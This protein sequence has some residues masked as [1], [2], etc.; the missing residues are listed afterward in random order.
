MPEDAPIFDAWT[1]LSFKRALGKRAQPGTSWLAPTWVGRH[2]RRLQ[3]YKMLQAYVDNAARMY[4]AIDSESAKSEHREYGDSALL[5]EVI[6]SA[7]LGDDQT[8][9]V[10]T[11]TGNPNARSQSLQTWLEAWADKE[12]LP[13]KV[14]E[15]ERNACNLGDGVYTLGWS[16][17]KK[18]VRLRVF[19]PGFYFPALD[20][21]NED[22]YPSRVHIAWEVDDDQLARAGQIKVRRITW[23]LRP[24][25][26]GIMHPWND[27]V[28]THSC[29]LTDAVWTLD[30][31]GKQTVD[32]LSGA[33]AVYMSDADGEIRDR[34]LG[35]DFVPVIHEPNTVSLLNHFGTSSLSRVLQIIDDLANADTDLQKASATTGF[36]PIALGGASLGDD[37]LTYRPGQVFE[38][39]DGKMDVLDTSRSLDALLKYVE[40]LQDR[41]SV[42]ARTPDSLLGRIGPHEVPSGVA[43]ALSFGPLS[44]MIDEMRLVRS[45]KYRILLRFV[46]RIASAGGQSDVPNV[47][48]LE[49]DYQFGSFL[50]QDLTDTISQARAMLG[51]TT[52]S[53]SM[54]SLETAISMLMEAGVPVDDIKAE[55]K[56]INERDFKGAIDLKE[57]TGTLDEVGSYLNRKTTEPPKPPPIAP[58]FG[59]PGAPPPPPGAPPVPPDNN[60]PPTP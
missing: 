54:V 21:G 41:L 48:D 27:E 49:P 51:D 52:A 8:I 17:S 24:I 53:A 44:S 42:N 9:A 33:Q 23:E 26:V 50:P 1:P 10:E 5:G 29:F 59:V 28:S 37:R 57:A 55:V 45:E 60:A 32:D 47:W 13:L 35:I 18:R 25:D 58:A 38:V 12:R 22:D 14:V 15:T 34:D 19:D 30:A 36:P 4:L 11:D 39:G 46:Q 7:V 6:R 3:A 43:L 20:D 56:R 31:A 40:S 2:A 16:A